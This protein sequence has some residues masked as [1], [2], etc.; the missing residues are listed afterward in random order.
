MVF[1]HILN[2]TNS[3][4][5]YAHEVKAD[6]WTKSQDF[7]FYDTRL[8][9]LDGLVMGIVG[10]GNIG[11]SVAQMAKA[12]GMKVVAV[13]SKSAPSLEAMGIE[14]AD[15][16]DELFSK[17][18]ILSLHCPLT[19]DT[20]HLVN[21]ERLALM[22]P[23]AIL[24]NTGRGPLID[25]LALADALNSQRLYAA[26]VDVLAEEPPRNGS[27]L[28]GARNCYITPHIAW[29]TLEAR[30]RLLT[31]AIENVKAFAEGNPVNVVNVER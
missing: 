13:S 12:F 19:E 24:I 4:A 6:R 10:L 5:H 18:D 11:M 31:I 15:S 17:S 8:I 3:V 21:T 23:T 7:C 14:K 30:Q 29:A 26:G 9:E 27:P 2:I 1:A 25:E 22:K 16:Y 20:Y 28:L